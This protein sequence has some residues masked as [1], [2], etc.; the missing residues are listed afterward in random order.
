MDDFVELLFQK[1]LISR[2]AKRSKDYNAI[3]DEFLNALTLFETV[4]K[5]KNHCSKLIDVLT[6]VGGPATMAG[7][8][9]REKWNSSMKD[10]VGID[11][12]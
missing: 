7:G 2:G 9:L 3:M 4:Q 11:F 5:C 12:L 6:D 8:V 10:N 1:R